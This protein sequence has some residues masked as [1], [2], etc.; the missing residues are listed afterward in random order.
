MGSRKTYVTVEETLENCDTIW[1][2]SCRAPTLNS[3]LPFDCTN[4]GLPFTS[5][6]INSHQTHTFLYGCHVVAIS[7]QTD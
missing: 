5:Y 2:L 6:R 4:V 1:K 7:A 3:N